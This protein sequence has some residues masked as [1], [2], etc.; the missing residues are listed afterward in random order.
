MELIPHV[1]DARM[2]TSI[3]RHVQ[4][5]VCQW[6]ALAGLAVWEVV[7][8]PPRIAV[9]LELAEVHRCWR[10]YE[11]EADVYGDPSVC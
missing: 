10:R 5:P 3:P 9:R 6:L 1:V 11:V 2:G 8:N 7:L 4:I